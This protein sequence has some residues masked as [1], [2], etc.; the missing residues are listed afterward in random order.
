[1]KLLLESTDPWVLRQKALSEKLTAF[2]FGRILLHLSQHRGAVGLVFKSDA[3]TKPTDTDEDETTDDDKPKKKTAKKDDGDSDGK[4]YDASQKTREAMK[5]RNARTFG[6]LMSILAEE[7]RNAVN[8]KDNKGN[9]VKK[10]KDKKP[11]TYGEKPIRNRQDSYEFHADRTLVREEFV[12]I[13]NFQSANNPELAK[14][15]TPELLTQLDD[16]SPDRNGVWRHQGL[17]FGQRR[18][19]WDVGTLGRCDLEPTDRLRVTRRS[20]C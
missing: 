18:T 17:L 14:L 8:V 6:E 5:L 13:W 1:M 15:L 3:D 10:M 2:E 11:V 19:F 7:R 9:L 20:P 16:A 12:E 4:I